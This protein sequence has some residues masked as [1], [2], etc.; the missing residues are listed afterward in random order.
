MSDF[1]SPSEFKQNTWEYDDDEEEPTQIDLKYKMYRRVYLWNLDELLSLDESSRN[2]RKT[3]TLEQCGGRKRR[4]KDA[5]PRFFAQNFTFPIGRQIPSLPYSS[6]YLYN[7]L[8]TIITF[9]RFN[10]SR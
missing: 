10:L 8:T 3:R 6:E 9:N 5:P 4:N 1:Y 7:L 2:C